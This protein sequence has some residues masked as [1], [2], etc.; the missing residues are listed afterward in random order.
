MKTYE[1]ICSILSLLGGI[2]TT[3]N[4]LIDDIPYILIPTNRQCLLLCSNSPTDLILDA[5]QRKGS[6]Y[7]CT[8]SA[9]PL[10]SATHL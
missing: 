7:P 9:L 2:N 1:F 5:T 10:N 4:G 8:A 3:N 6:H